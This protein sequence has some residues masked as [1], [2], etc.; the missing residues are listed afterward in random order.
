MDTAFFFFANHFCVFDNQYAYYVAEKSLGNVLHKSNKD[1]VILASRKLQ[2][3]STRP[4][5]CIDCDELFLLYASKPHV[6]VL[7]CLD[8][9]P[10]RQFDWDGE[11]EGVGMAWNGI[12]VNGQM[13]CLR[14]KRGFI[15]ADRQDGQIV[16]RCDCSFGPER[17]PTNGRALMVGPEIL[18]CGRSFGIQ[19]FSHSGYRIDSFGSENYSDIC[20][21]GRFLYAAD[22]CHNR[23]DKFA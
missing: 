6:V 22:Q 16:K 5:M 8:L 15:L 19:V 7:N 4:D 14:T 11:D 10:K 20:F 13:I 18:V 12:S 23:I 9:A 1:G 21:D 17:Q 3:S 2:H